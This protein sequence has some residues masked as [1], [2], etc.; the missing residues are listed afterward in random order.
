MVFDK[1]YEV[2]GLWPSQPKSTETIGECTAAAGSGSDGG[3]LNPSMRTN[4]SRFTV[5]FSDLAW[6]SVDIQDYGNETGEVPMFPRAWQ[7]GRYLAKYAERYLSPNH[8][9][10]ILRLGQRVLR[11]TR[12]TGSERVRN[13][14]TVE[15]VATGSID[16][17]QD[18]QVQSEGFDYL[19]VAAGYF[20]SP[21]I[22]DIPG[23]D[24]FGERTVHSSCLHDGNSVR[25][26]LSPRLDGPTEQ[27]R[28]VVV[29]GSLSGAEAASMLALHLSSSKDQFPGQKESHQVHHV[30][31]RPFWAIPT[32]LP[33]E[34]LP[35]PFSEQREKRVSFLPLDLVM[36]D[37]SRRPPGP[38][39]YAF[40]PVSTERAQKMNEYFYTLLG[41][42]YTKS[43]KIGEEALQKPWV[44]IGND[45]AE[46]IRSGAISPT[47]GRVT[48]VHRERDSNM[49]SIDISLPSGGRTVRL[50]NIAAIVLATGFTH[51]ESLSFLPNTVLSRLE[52]SENDPSIPLIL[53]GMGTSHAEIPDLGFVGYYRG[54]YWGVMEMQARFLAR[55]WSRDG[56][57]ASYDT[58]SMEKKTEERQ[59]LRELRNMDPHIH[60]GQFPMGDYIGLMESFAREL[61]MSRTPLSESNREANEERTGPVLPA[62]YTYA[63]ESP[64]LERTATLSSLRSILF[65][66]ESSA[67][68][69]SMAIF[70]AL[71]GIWNFTRT[72]HQGPHEEGQIEKTIKGTATFH[73][74]YPTSPIYEKE[75]LYKE[76]EYHPEATAAKATKE[77]IY[78]LCNPENGTSPNILVRVGVTKTSYGLDVLALASGDLSATYTVRATGMGTPDS[79]IPMAEDLDCSFEY[80]FHFQGVG[81][82]SWECVAVRAGDGRSPCVRTVYERG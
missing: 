42:E 36:Y 27:G 3:T 43:G 29:G 5:A 56:P 37:L 26:L 17:D 6:E 31:T 15:W 23:L 28:V 40:G 11:T 76:S 78:Y 20:A 63:N 9:R 24:G 66:E 13:R 80:G 19:V 14:W 18:V 75:Y 55:N 35:Y 71:H 8:G 67:T 65:P 82:L 2:G 45:Y 81:I 7:V 62:R 57:D 73:P 60:R 25:R 44:A 70:R 38:I 68:A 59:R 79:P 54:P 52:Y 64:S 61:E 32:Y 48:A 41:S 49:A 22:P 33:Q 72:Y 74:R 53:D 30:S 39:E 50:H 47:I 12:E 58:L 1:R 69:T 77:S 21:C 10:D 4:L 51:H 46:Y 34:V 16:S